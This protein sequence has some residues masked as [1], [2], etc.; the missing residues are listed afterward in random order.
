MTLR[1]SEGARSNL[2]NYWELY[3]SHETFGKYIECKKNVVSR[4]KER[5]PYSYVGYLQSNII[6]SWL[7]ISRIG[8]IAM[9]PVWISWIYTESY[10]KSYTGK[11][12]A[13]NILDC[14]NGF[15]TLHYWDKLE[16]HLKIPVGVLTQQCTDC[17]AMKS[18]SAQQ[19]LCAC[20]ICSFI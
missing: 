15:I 5:F 9:I 3:Q 13:Q 4:G 17:V 8:K 1:K 11:I 20:F 18:S 19:E 7:R 2:P 12:K 14:L 10:I 16:S 6:L